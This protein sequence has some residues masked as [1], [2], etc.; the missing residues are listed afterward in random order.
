[1]C[2]SDVNVISVVARA[3]D[4]VGRIGVA[5]VV[6]SRC[7]FP[8]LTVH[9]SSSDTCGLS[10]LGLTAADSKVILGQLSHSGG[11]PSTC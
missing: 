5:A 7:P 10:R 3:I 9:M 6:L 8:G 2:M 1:M 11:K 4:G